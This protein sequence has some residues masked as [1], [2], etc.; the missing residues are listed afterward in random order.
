MKKSVCLFISIL[1][2]FCGCTRQEYINA[3]MYLT[4]LQKKTG[5]VIPRDNILFDDRTATI[6][7]KNESKAEL[8]IRA[9]AKDEKLQKLCRIS[10][11]APCTAESYKLLEEVFS[12]TVSIFAN[13]EPEEI[14]KALHIPSK[15][16]TVFMVTHHET[17]YNRYA[18]YLTDDGYFVCIEC[19]EDCREGQEKRTLT[20]TY[21]V[22]ES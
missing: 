9:E 22:G 15:P 7:V 12:C 1:I 6:Y 10:L 13:D 2:F 11:S 21:R 16:P 3:E 18:C 8:L 17:V 19:K 5:I 4:E 20:Q 14:I